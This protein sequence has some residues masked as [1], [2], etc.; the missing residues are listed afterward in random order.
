MRIVVLLKSHHAGVTNQHLTSTPGPTGAA[1]ARQHGGRT[2]LRSAI[3]DGVVYPKKPSVASAGGTGGNSSV[4]L[5]LDLAPC[6]RWVAT[7]Y[8]M[9]PVRDVQ[10]QQA[11]R[12]AGRKVHEG[13]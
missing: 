6:D 9:L 4:E 1:P 10:T 12:G 3:G 8:L 7:S 5:V 13:V 11:S 2:G